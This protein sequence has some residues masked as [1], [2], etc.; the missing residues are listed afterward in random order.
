MTG[1]CAAEK[2]KS[3]EAGFSLIEAMFAIVILGVGLCALMAMFGSAVYTMQ[4]AQEDQIARQKAREALEAAVS[5]RNDT[6]ITFAQ[7]Q[8]VSNGGIFKD[9]FG[10]LYQAGPNGIPGTTS[11][12]STPD[13]FRLPGPDGIMNTAD[14]RIIPLN[15]FQR[16]ILINN[17]YNSD[18]TLNADMRKIAVTV[19]ILGQER[20]A[21]DYTITSYISRFN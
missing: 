8:N 14:D 3:R 12:G 13:Y 18:G 10:T 19:R 9:G 5:A 21:R 6:T 11:D 15:N 20:G 2:R 17:V 16:Q 4:F 7:L 1:F